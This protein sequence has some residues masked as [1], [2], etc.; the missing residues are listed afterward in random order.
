MIER[1]RDYP[2]PAELAELYA[3]PNDARRW[4]EHE[5]RTRLTVDLGRARFP[6]RNVVAD[7]AA[8]NGIAAV[9]LT[10][11]DVIL[12]DLAGDL[13][14]SGRPGDRTRFLRGPIEE[15]L[16]LLEDR[17]VDVLVLGEILEH[18]E[19]PWHVLRRAGRVA[20]GLILSTP[21]EEVPGINVEHVWRWDL[22]GIRELLESTGWRP[23][24]SLVLEYELP[25]NLAAF[26]PYRCQLW[27]ASR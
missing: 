6:V 24:A 16:E 20:S 1:V 21:L 19:D 22:A 18:L 3:R 11:R 10:T 4:P 25:T 26:S 13:G 27:T 14:V 8:G 23:T 9:E 15:T 5:L 12:G 7:L 2:S 17:S